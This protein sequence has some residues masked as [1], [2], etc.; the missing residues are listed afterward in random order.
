MSLIK[1]FGLGETQMSEATSKTPRY[2]GETTPLLIEGA[3]LTHY[4]RS[5]FFTKGGRAIKELVDDLRWSADDIA[6]V[7]GGFGQVIGDS[8]TGLQIVRIG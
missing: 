7:A 2:S 4:I 6:V 8:D 1:T 5:Q 3:W